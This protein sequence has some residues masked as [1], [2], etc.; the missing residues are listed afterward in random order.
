MPE[1]IRPMLCTLT[2]EPFQD[3]RYLYEIKL[4]GYRIIA[5]KSKSNVR[6]ASRS[7]LDYT[8][9]Y[10]LVAQALKKI[11]HDVVL[12]GEMIVLNKEGHADFDSLQKYNGQKTPLAY[13]TFDM[14]WIDGYDIKSFSLTERKI[15]LQNLLQDNPVLRYNEV[16]DDGVALYKQAQTKGVE[17]IVAKRKDSAYLENDRSSNWY[18]IPTTIRQEFVIGAWAESER[19]R[20]FRS[21]LFGAYNQKGQLEWIGRSGGGYK[22]KDMPGILR[23]LKE[24]E[25]DKS[26]FINKIL[27]TKGATIH[28]VKPKLVANFHFATW[29]TSGRIRKPAT[30]LGFRKDKNAKQVVRE[31]PR[32]VKEDGS[33]KSAKKKLRTSADS[34]WREIEKQE[35]SS[36]ATVNLGNCD[37]QIDNI[38]RQ[39]WKNVTKADLIEYYHNICPFILPHLKDRPLSLHIKPVNAGAPGFYIKDMEGRQPECAGIFS[40]ERKHPKKGKRNRIDYLVCNNEETLLYM[41]NLGC[42]DINPWTS[43]TQNSDYPD[44]IIIDLDPT[45]EDFGKAIETAIAA[46]KLFDKLNL[47]TFPKTSGKTGIHIYI[48]CQGFSF[49]DARTIATKICALIHELVPDLTTTDVTVS[50]RGS[51]LYI[52][53]NQNDYADTVAAPYSARP[54]HIPTVSTPLDW[55][56]VNPNLK[57]TDFTIDTIAKRLKKKGDPFKNIMDQK[58]RLINSKILKRFL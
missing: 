22:E 28:Y 23:Q 27:D 30:F 6:L 41:V 26:P 54:Y 49:P 1:S 17:G 35:I 42:I 24:L 37:I 31:I 7:G 48:P 14:M 51:R 8:A 4:D 10:P 25:T 19:G 57:T 12:D 34:N 11:K 50:K 13:F 46:K 5:Y 29:T 9:K 38:E 55:K 56:E 18:K 39:L 20:A 33:S 53:P 16:F 43:R 36:E 3:D 47:V 58:L 15:L 44:Y 40:D 2:R 52:D 45:D 32:E 21:L